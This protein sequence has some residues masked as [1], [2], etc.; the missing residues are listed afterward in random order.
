MKDNAPGQQPAEHLHLLIDVSQ[1]ITSILEIDELLAQ[2]VQLIQ[3]AFGFY[4]VGIGLVEGDEVV[5]RVGAGPLWDSPDFQ[6]KPAR[7]KIGRE[8]IA[9]WVAHTGQ[10]LLVPDVSQEPRYVWMQG[11]QTQSELTVPIVIKG[12]VI[13][14]LDVQIDQLNGFNDSDIETMVALASQTGI[15]IENAR[16][17]ENARKMAVL[18]ERQRLA[19]ELHDS[20][21]QSLYG[22]TLYSQAAAF[23][24][25]AEHYAD[26][27]KSI[28]EIN[29][30]AQEALA[31]MR[32]LIY[33]LRP[34]VLEKEGLLAALQARLTAVEGRARIKY[35]LKADLMNRLP[36]A[37]EEGLY[38]IAQEAL[39]NVL[40]HARAHAV[41]VTLRQSGSLVNLEIS[42]D[43]VGFDL[44]NVYQEGTMGLRDMRARANELGAT[45]SIL[46]RPG[47]GTRIKVE[48][49]R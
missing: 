37:L 36:D 9:G 47:S 40:K 10:L 30:T 45:L 6:F 43:G 29:A 15:A 33:Q 46:S 31:E 35:T 38:H 7:L 42:D 39:N 25:A 11:S 13:G 5:Y 3:Q 34:P 24:L 26:A 4:H 2:V 8:G 27:E 49:S 17:Y 22:I 18:E 21:T 44:D 14:V 20:V 12:Q 23:Q 16:L 32:L 19:R 28:D 41:N 1:R 48:V